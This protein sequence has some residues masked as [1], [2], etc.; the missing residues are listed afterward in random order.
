MTNVQRWLAHH[1]TSTATSAGSPIV[2]PERFTEL[3]SRFPTGV[4][5]VTTTGE[6]DEPCGFTCSS[7]C[8]LSLSPPLL[9]V[10]VNNASSTLTRIRTRGA[11]AVNLLGAH[12]RE[13]AELFS[14]AIA[15]R[16][17]RIRWERTPQRSLP[18]LVNHAH[19]VT[20]CLVDAAYTAGDHTI[21]VGAVS[22]VIVLCEDGIPLLHGLRRYALWPA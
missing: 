17:S 3:M 11:F 16:F 18:F 12:G 14:S 13:A 9:L 7:L 20:E 10:C 8:S 1:Q 4:A 6:R 21:V 19:V 5:V 15:D 2:E 22:D